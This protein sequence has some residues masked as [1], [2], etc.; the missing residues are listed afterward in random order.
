MGLQVL[1]RYR[2]RINRLHQHQPLPAQV[3]PGGYYAPGREFIAHKAA[4]PEDFFI[5]SYA[6]INIAHEKVDMVNAPD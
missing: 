3:C 4:L 2:F 5:V 6:I 1:P